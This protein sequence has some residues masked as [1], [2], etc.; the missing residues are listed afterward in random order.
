[1]ATIEGMRERLQHAPRIDMRAKVTGAA[2]YIEDLP[3]PAGLVYGAVLSSEYSHAKIVSIDA[4]KASQLSGVIGVL[5][6]DH[7]EGFH[8]LRPLP[9]N[10]HF[11]LTEDQ[12][13]LAID[14]VRFNGEVVAIVAA[15]D[16]RTAQRAVDLIDVVYEPLP[17][18]Y[19]AVGALSPGAPLIH[20]QK[21]TNLLLQDKME[22]GNVERGFK[23]ADRIFEETY[24]SPAMFHH[25]MENVGGCIAQYA[26]GKIDLLVPT[27]APFRDGNE[28][29][30]FFRLPP[31]D[32]R[33]RVPF[34][35]GGFGSKNIVNAHL[36]AL[37]LS[38]KIGGRP[39]KLVPSAEESFK[40]NSRHAMLFKA[41]IGVKLDGTITALQVE[42][43]VDTGAYTTGA[44]TATHNAVISAW[45]CYRIPHLSIHGRCAYTNKVPAGHTRATGKVQTTWAVECLV[46]SVA[47]QLG[48]EPTTFRRKN[49]LVRGEFVTKG[50]PHMDTDFLEL[51]DRVDAAIENPGNSFASDTEQTKPAKSRYIRGRGMALGLR[52]GSFGGGQTDAL[53]IADTRGLVTIRHNAPDLGQGIFNLIS[54]IAA[55]SL[56][57][58]QEQISVAQPDTALR[59][60]FMGVNSQRTTIQL[61]TAVYNACENLTREMIRAAVETKGGEP[62]EWQLIEGYLCRAER[63]FPFA[64][65]VR[66]IGPEATIQS[67]GAYR[68]PP[69]QKDSSSFAGMDHWAPSAAI[70]E[71]EVDPDTGEFRVLQYAVAVDAGEV[72]HYRSA[73]AQLLGGAVMGFGHALF[74]EVVYSEGQILNGDPFQYRLPVLRDLP[75]S[76]STSIVEAG[77]G[78]GPFGSKGMSQTSIVTVAPA[79]G[80]AIY[81]AIGARV[82]S[83]PITPEK[84]LAAL[85]KLQ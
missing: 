10:E 25:P 47:R 80:N 76:M 69:V 62:E 45:G 61:G 65:I 72:L 64:E 56:G 38:K 39:I 14:K 74:E 26:D 59:L 66:L 55:R 13:F 29:A 84:I 4:G 27:N 19:D 23:E 7:L 46:D 68:A 37:F 60:A 31:E 30:H 1:M 53:A 33:V 81:D 48:M 67:A 6:R 82:K 44:A 73:I 77:D 2:K 79:V 32:V 58:P 28:I 20:E 34:I 8:P 5:H 51:I 63:S 43:V 78:P 40:Q 71:V 54:V 11:N 3:E 12:P 9:R 83:L 50:T 70:A 16:L 75:A 24:D 52:H 57:I 85:G 17:H 36:A 22:W 15:E 41:K 49:V 21:G 42:I 35:G 18:V